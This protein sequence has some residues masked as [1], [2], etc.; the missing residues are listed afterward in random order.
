[1]PW[2]V[3][4]NSVGNLLSNSHQNVYNRELAEY[5]NAF[6]LEMWNK[7][8]E[9]NSPVETMKRLTQAGINPRNVN[10]MQTFSNATEGP[11]S[12]PY[13]RTSP[14]SAFSDIARTTLEFRQMEAATE[15]LQ[16]EKVRT[17]TQAATEQ[18]R[19][20]D[21][22]SQIDYRKHNL[23]H[24]EDRL[25]LSIIDGLRRAWHEGDT[26]K[27]TGLFNT[28][29]PELTFDQETFGIEGL[30][31]I[32]QNEGFHLSNLGEELVNE[33]RE[34]QKSIN[35]NEIKGFNDIPSEWRWIIELLIRALK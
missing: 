28:Y 7:Q 32:N 15:K 4:I 33:L 20:L 23:S 9:Y 24:E 26:L 34:Q 18:A 31:R 6:N 11:Q 29:L 12:V 10:G 19:A 13:E 3:L 14:L 27:G 22:L 17:A 8:N 35:A 5:Q 2:S 25:R 16:A 1:M 30:K 21:Y